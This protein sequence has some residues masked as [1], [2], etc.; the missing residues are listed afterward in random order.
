MYF[1]PEKET[2]MQRERRH[3]DLKRGET[4]RRKPFKAK[5]PERKGPISCAGLAVRHL[6]KGERFHNGLNRNTVGSSD[7]ALGEIAKNTTRIQQ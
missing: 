6:L 4:I 3:K 1:D 2:R 7:K 5:R